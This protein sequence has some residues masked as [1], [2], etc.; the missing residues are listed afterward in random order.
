MKGKILGK[1]VKKDN[2]VGVL[3]HTFISLFTVIFPFFYGGVVLTSGI[4]WLLVAVSLGFF[5]ALFYSIK[6]FKEK[7]VVKAFSIILIYFTLELIVFL[8]SFSSM[9]QHLM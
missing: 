6:M 8:F 7:K 2:L 4:S 5:V 1:Q 3:Y 9:L